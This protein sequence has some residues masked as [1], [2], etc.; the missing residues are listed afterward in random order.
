MYTFFTQ[1]YHIDIIIHN[2]YED[3]VY[4]TL[5]AIPIICGI[6]VESYKVMS[7]NFFELGDNII[8]CL[9][10]NILYTQTNEALISC[11]YLPYMPHINIYIIHLSFLLIV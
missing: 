3:D 1:A 8:V 6:N 11:T 5:Y 9:P 7:G 2:V 10:V 4:L